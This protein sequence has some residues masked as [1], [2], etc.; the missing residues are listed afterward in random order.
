MSRDTATGRHNCAEGSVASFSLVDE[1]AAARDH[2]FFIDIRK[3]VDL[4]APAFH[5]QVAFPLFAFNEG[6]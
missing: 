2:A 6:T 1:H 4:L 3:A 5:K